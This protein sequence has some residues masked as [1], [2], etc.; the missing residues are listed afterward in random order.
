MELEILL[1]S[2][3]LGLL[4]LVTMILFIKAFKR[5]FNEDL[6]LFDKIDKSIILVAG[7]QILFLTIAFLI[8]SCDLFFVII[9]LA[10]LFQEAV[11][12]MILS[13]LIFDESK[14]E[15]IYKT[16][17][18]LSCLIS[19]F[20]LISIFQI[21]FLENSNLEVNFIVFSSFTLFINFISICFGLKVLYIIQ[22]YFQKEINNSTPDDSD[23]SEGGK[24]HLKFLTCEE[25]KNR[26]M[27][28]YILVSVH[29]I[30][31]VL[32][33]IWDIIAYECSEG[34]NEYYRYFAPSNFLT[35]VLFVILKAIVNLTPVWVIY[36]VFYWRNRSAFNDETALENNHLLVEFKRENYATCDS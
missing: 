6:N 2:V 33:F 26:K 20:G 5:I 11:L 1:E 10:R 9:R 25:M 21:I 4:S 7:I 22:D 8:L 17:M 23:C 32:Q 28:I 30:S 3:F 18:G 31:A 36:F 19:I 29:S 24:N 13:F 35:L 27:Q 12:W 14:Y 34:K 16:M 15:I